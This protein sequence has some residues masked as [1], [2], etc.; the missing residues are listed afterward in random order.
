MNNSY[1]TSKVFKIKINLYL[2]NRYPMY[3][4]LVTVYFCNCYTTQLQASSG[5]DTLTTS[6]LYT[7]P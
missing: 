5:N 3:K 7:L 4:S 6:H 2:S 1:E